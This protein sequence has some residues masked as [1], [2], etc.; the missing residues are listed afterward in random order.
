MAE[1]DI[2][3]MYGKDA[4]TQQVARATCGGVEYP[5][6]EL[7]YS[8]PVGPKGQMEKGVGIGGTNHGNAV[9]QG[10]H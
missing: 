9:N 8:P 5:P 4:S 6:K 7:P 1:R 2:L 10:R 3:S